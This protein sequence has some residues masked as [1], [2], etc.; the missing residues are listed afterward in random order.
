MRGYP[1][2]VL[3]E[4]QLAFIARHLPEPHAPTGRPAYSNLEL[5]PG[6]LRVLRSGC[7]WRDLDLPGY[8]SGVTHW[9]RLRYWKQRSHFK[10][11]WK[12]LL[13][14]LVMGKWLDP[15]VFIIDGTL[16][17]SYEFKE[18]TGYSGKHRLVGMK[19]SIVVDGHG[20]PLAVSVA[21]GNVHD[22][23]L[24]YLTM[25]NMY[26]PPP[27]L[28]SIYATVL[29]EQVVLLGDKGYDSLQFRRF[30][31]E[32]GYLPDIP[33][34]KGIPIEPGAEELYAHDTARSKRRSVVERT[35][36][37]LKKFRRLRY[38]V[39]RTTESFEAFLYLA[40]I[41]ICARRAI[42]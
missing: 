37:W 42:G 23:A 33:K 8:P 35:N 12:R 26:R 18:R 2:D 22:G 19:L 11:L 10:K 4:R 7:R 15:S 1:T 6:I 32:Q 17:P 20:T 27:L 29:P 16:I 38:R 34:R 24:G 14:V 36:G 21:P 31:K 40:G 9:R 41:V 39:D 30:V 28:R 5:L 3:T 25:E 13:D